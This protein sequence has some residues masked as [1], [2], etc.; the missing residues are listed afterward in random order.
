MSANDDLSSLGNALRSVTRTMHTPRTHQRIER[1]AG[2][3]LDKLSEVILLQ[4]TGDSDCKLRLTDIA[5]RVG[6][7][8]SSVSRKAQK[9]ETL[10]LVERMPDPEDGRAS[11]LRITGAGT[12][13]VTSLARARS[14]LADAALASW[15]DK[16]RKQLTALLQRFAADLSEQLEKSGD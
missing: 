8:L 1:S 12:T 7:E 15:S 10:G 14:D 5:E 3:Q 13:Q 11:K 9:L 2:V 16:D 6:V 4:A